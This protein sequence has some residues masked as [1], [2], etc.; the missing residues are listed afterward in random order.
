M[1]AL[2]TIFFL[3]ML[4]SVA[5]ADD[6]HASGDNQIT[7]YYANFPPVT[8]PDGPHAGTGFYD[9][10]TQF[11]IERL[12]GYTHDFQV[13]N[14][15]RIINE[16]RLQEPVCCATLYKT[17]A[18]ED[19]VTFSIPVVVVLPSGVVARKTDRAKLSAYIRDDN[20]LSLE[21]VLQDGNLRVGVSK[22]RAYTGEIDEI[23]NRYRPSSLIE[24][25]AGK[26][27]FQGLLAMLLAGRVDLIIGYPTEAQFVSRMFGQEDQVIFLPVAEMS[28][29]YTLGHVGC[30]KN[31]WGQE[32]IE[33]VDLILKKH[34][35]TPEFT[36]Y[37][38]QWLDEDTIPAYRRI[39]QDVFAL[40]GT[41]P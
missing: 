33:K 30:P 13:A 31:E 10:I 14:F 2:S 34:R 12:D 28:Q 20:T 41:T 29:T 36:G 24:E 25:R 4:A 23:L 5:L 8:I 1:K 37:Y 6:Q 9:R 16:I 3:L 21:S 39:T 32:I 40:P 7:W 18:R 22:G 11:I 15:K 38:E 17:P 26:D 19:Y 35:A 27:V